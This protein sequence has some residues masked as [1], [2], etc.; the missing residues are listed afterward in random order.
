VIVTERDRRMESL[1]REIRK[2]NLSL[3]VL[4]APLAELQT[5][6]MVDCPFLDLRDGGTPENSR[7]PVGLVE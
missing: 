5:K 6:S 7:H 1:C 3:R 2:R 4:M